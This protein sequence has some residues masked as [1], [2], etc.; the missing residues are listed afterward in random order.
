[1]KMMKPTGL[2]KNKITY[3]SSGHAKGLYE[4]IL[5]IPDFDNRYRCVVYIIPRNFESFCVVLVSAC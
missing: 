3:A 1:M 2:R 4:I 5:L